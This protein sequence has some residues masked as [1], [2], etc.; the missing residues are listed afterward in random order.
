MRQHKLNI[1]AGN[2]QHH[3]QFSRRLKFN[4][5]KNKV[6]LVWACAAVSENLFHKVFA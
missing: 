3:L 4:F 1:N 5:R 6:F 2:F